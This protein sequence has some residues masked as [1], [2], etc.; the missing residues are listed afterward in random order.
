[1]KTQTR[2]ASALVIKTL[3]HVAQPGARLLVIG[4]GAFLVNPVTHD[5]WYT[6]SSTFDSLRANGWIEAPTAID[7]DVAEAFITEAGRELAQA[8]E[9]A[10]RGYT[11]LELE[12]AL[13][14][15]EAAQ[16]QQEPEQKEEESNSTMPLTTF[17]RVVP[18]V[19]DITSEQVGKC[20]KLIIDGQIV[21][22]VENERGDRDM[23]GEIIEYV[24]RYSPERGYSCTCAAGAE[25]FAH[26]DHAS[27]VCKCVRWTVAAALE[28]RVYMRDLAAKQVAQEEEQ[29]KRP[30]WYNPAN[31]TSHY[32]IRRLVITS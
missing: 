22:A 2:K 1:M 8:I 9:T 28:E 5:H 23:D 19:T 30:A 26:V 15:G 21:Y 13:E 7:A 29:G 24:V 16:A 20:H 10:K 17:E 4:N 12:Q 3:L 31:E 6:N 27:G 14:E 25:G 32:D 18:H 11:Q